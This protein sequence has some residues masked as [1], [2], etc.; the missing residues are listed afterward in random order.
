MES[1]IPRYRLIG[2][3]GDQLPAETLC[4][5]LESAAP[6]YLRRQRWF[7]SKSREIS[8]VSL[9]DYAVLS[10]RPCFYVLTV[11]Q[12]S[13]ED[14]S[15]ET[16]YLP[17]VLGLEASIEPASGIG[18]NDILAV[19]DSDS[20]PA[21]I[22]DALADRAFCKE[23][24]RLI[25]EVHRVSAE[26]GAFEFSRV[27]SVGERYLQLPA[28]ATTSVRRVTTEQSNSSV[29]YGIADH[30]VLIMKCFRKIESGVNPDL[31]I[32]HFLTTKTGFGNVPLLAGY[33]V[34]RGRDGFMGPVVI[35]QTFVASTGNCWDYTI[36][37][38]KGYYEQAFRQRNTYFHLTGE[39]DNVPSQRLLEEN[40]L[41]QAT[42]Q[43]AGGY[44]GEIAKL[45]QI[46]AD[47]HLALVSDRSDPCFCP[48]PI[49][50][51]D[52]EGWMATMRDHLRRG[53]DTIRRRIDQYPQPIQED[54]ANILSKEHTYA[55]KINDLCLLSDGGVEK[56]RHHGD[57]HLGQ[58]L[59]TDGEFVILDFEGE[60]ARPL[61]ERR[62]K[63][64]PLKDVAG[65]LRSFSYAAYAGLLDAAGWSFKTMEEMEPWAAAWHALVSRSFLEGYLDR[66]S[67]GGARLLPDSMDATHKVLS[68]Y[69]LD[70]AIY[71]LSYEINNRPEWLP[72]PVKGMSR[73]LEEA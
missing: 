7:G 67:S 31:E 50:P 30:A 65:M 70:K 39:A 20:G 8:R 15:S 23:F 53:M 4:R 46:T 38:V 29:I 47:L 16:F 55:E 58:V 64:S 45:G 49:T 17:L 54:L 2:G 11:I 61:S 34:Y 72:I 28:D 62:A 51:L 52:V 13:Y 48:E 21:L 40:R 41:W 19:L 60:P 43:F 73:L 37:H 56:A 63:V 27:A 57:Y 35:L 71:E 69:Q 18:P 14:S 36:R 22:Y 6:A 68:V 10:E 9:R 3:L 44:A 59:K 5:A 26:D 66:I 25:A 12:A 32:S 24:L 1:N 33:T 42:R